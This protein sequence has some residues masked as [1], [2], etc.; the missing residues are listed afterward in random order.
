MGEGAEK[1]RINHKLKISEKY[2]SDVLNGYKPFELRKNDRDF[3][4]WEI[5]ELSQV[6]EF[7]TNTGRSILRKISYVLKDCPEYG[8]KDGYCILGLE[9]L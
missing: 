5:I 9:S 8:L 1:M 2:Y 7:G 3:K 6:N 4:L